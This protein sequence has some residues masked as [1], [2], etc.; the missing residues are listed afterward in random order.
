MTKSASGKFS[1]FGLKGQ[2]DRFLGCDSH[3]VA[4]A[5]APLL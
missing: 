4:A 3:A 2:V 5:K 1:A